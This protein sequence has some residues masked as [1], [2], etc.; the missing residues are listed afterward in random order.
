MVYDTI[1]SYRLNATIV[2]GYLRSKFGN[3]KFYVEHVNDT[4]RFWIARLLSDA[5][6]QELLALRIQDE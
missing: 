2:D 1:D 6:K 4:Y 3:Y 5:E